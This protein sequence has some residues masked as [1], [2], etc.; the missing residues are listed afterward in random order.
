[1]N[2]NG[3]LLRWRLGAGAL[4]ALAWTLA[5]G[6]ALRWWKPGPGHRPNRDRVGKRF[7]RIASLP[8]WN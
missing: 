5:P 6:E 4:A 2:P 3:N 7:A 1:M 8:G